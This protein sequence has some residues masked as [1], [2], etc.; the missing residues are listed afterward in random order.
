MPGGIPLTS[1]A[2][3]EKNDS[4]GQARASGPYSPVNSSGDGFML[5]AAATMRLFRMSVGEMGGMIDLMNL[6][7]I[8]SMARGLC[9]NL[10]L[11]ADLA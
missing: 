3:A 7:K 4:R 8:Q 2:W 10:M 9:A 11:L 5:E 1:L 6:G